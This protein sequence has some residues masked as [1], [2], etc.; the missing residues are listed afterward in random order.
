MRPMVLKDVRKCIFLGRIYLYLNI[1]T[2]VV[3]LFL[4]FV[5]P[6]SWLLSCTSI[7]FTGEKTSEVE[8]WFDSLIRIYQS[9]IGMLLTLLCCCKCCIMYQHRHRVTEAESVMTQLNRLPD[10]KWQDLSLPDESKECSFCLMEYQDE[11]SVV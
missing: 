1:L 3:I 5:D 9:L 10:K 7:E 2:L 6:M 8:N 11:E 4:F